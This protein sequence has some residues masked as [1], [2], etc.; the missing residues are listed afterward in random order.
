M[1]LPSA[2][3]STATPPTLGDTQFN[4]S[5]DIPIDAICFDIRTAVQCFKFIVSVATSRKLGKLCGA[6]VYWTIPF[7]IP[8]S[9]H[10]K[11]SH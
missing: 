1:R 3:R 7:L 9:G 8:R 11:I 4:K 6:F 5:F 2:S 10:S